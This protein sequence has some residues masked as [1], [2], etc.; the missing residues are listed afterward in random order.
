MGRK[1]TMRGRPKP[2]KRCAWCTKEFTP[3]KNR[4]RPWAEEFCSLKCVMEAGEKGS[5]IVGNILMPGEDGKGGPPMMM[6]R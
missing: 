1:R 3:V 6:G 4:M 2:K 5:K